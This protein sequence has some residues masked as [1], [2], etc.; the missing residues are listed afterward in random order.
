MTAEFFSV[1][2]F[3][4]GREDYVLIGLFTKLEDAEAFARVREP[5]YLKESR[6]VSVENGY[7]IQPTTIDFLIEG[8]LRARLG[9]LAKVLTT[10]IGA[11]FKTEV[12]KAAVS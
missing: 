12:S 11:V 10:A 9:E 6:S 4:A 3:S 2:D 5:G 1:H 8:E 7:L